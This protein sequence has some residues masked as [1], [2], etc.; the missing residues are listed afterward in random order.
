MNI[1][2]RIQA[3]RLAGITLTPA[4]QAALA[5]AI[6]RHVGLLTAGQES[7]APRRQQDTPPIQPGPSSPRVE[8]LARAIASDIAAALPKA[9]PA[10]PAPARA[11]GSSQGRARRR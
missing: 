9:P 1:A 8:T 4:E 6:G 3:L 7:A 10:P 2:I 5:E 11:G